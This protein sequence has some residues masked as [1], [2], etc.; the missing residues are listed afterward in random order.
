M[1]GVVPHNVLHSDYD[2]EYEEDDITKEEYLALKRLYLGVTEGREDD[3]TAP[4][5]YMIDIPFSMT[6]DYEGTSFGKGTESYEYIE[7]AESML[8]KHGIPFPDHTKVFFSSIKEFYGWGDYFDG[9][10][11][12][13]ILHRKQS[14]DTET[15]KGSKEGQAL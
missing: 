7:Q 14:T 12:S 10:F 2:L 1:C 6:S 13:I 4:V 11:L 5:S 15:G 3:P 8:K 9:S